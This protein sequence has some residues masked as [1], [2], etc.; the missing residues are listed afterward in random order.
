MCK[1]E[2]GGLF[3]DAGGDYI[4]CLQINLAMSFDLVCVKQSSSAVVMRVCYYDGYCISGQE[5]NNTIHLQ[6]AHL[7]THPNPTDQKN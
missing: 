3:L 2:M 5:A 7:T 1:V 6:S 4:T